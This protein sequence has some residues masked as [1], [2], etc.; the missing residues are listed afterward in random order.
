MLF[1]SHATFSIPLN[2]NKDVKHNTTQAALF[3]EIN[4]LGWQAIKYDFHMTSFKSF[5]AIN[6]FVAK[7]CVFGREAYKSKGIYSM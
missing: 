5:K 7:M 6:T 1:R 4:D 2:K 3:E